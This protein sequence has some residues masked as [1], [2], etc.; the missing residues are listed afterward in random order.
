MGSRQEMLA[1]KQ[2]GQECD[3]VTKGSTLLLLNKNAAVEHV[4]CSLQ[5]PENIYPHKQQGDESGLG[6]GGGGGAGGAGRMTKSW[7]K[8]PHAFLLPLFF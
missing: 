6:A 2:T 1:G 5:I 8:A 4:V 3:R 7:R